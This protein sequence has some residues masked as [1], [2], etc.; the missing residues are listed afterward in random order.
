MDF[1]AVYHRAW[2]EYCY[3]KNQDELIINLKTGYDVDRV[4]IV[5]GD[6]YQAGIAGGAEKW[7]GTKEEIFFK[8]DL[9]YQRWWTTTLYPVYKRLKY[10]FILKAGEETY[11]YFENG[12]L[13][14]EQMEE[15]G[16]MLQYFICP[17]MNCS[18]ISE[19]PGWVPQTVWYQIFPERF[20]NGD[21]AINQPGI[22][23][24]E[25]R[26][27]TNEE[28]FGGDMEGIISKLDYLQDL[29]ITGIYLTPVFDSPSAHKYDTRD[30][31]KI[32]PAFGSQETFRRM[33]TEAHRRGIH[34]MLDMVFNHCGNQFPQWQDVVEKGPESR[35]YHWFMVNKW[36]FDIDSNNTKDSRYYS[37]AFH[38][39]M[40]K[41]NT[42]NQEVREYLLSVCTYWVKE[43]GVDGLRFDVGN[44]IAHTFVRYLREN[45]KKLKPDIYLLGEIWHDASEWLEG[46]QYDGVM[47]YPLTESIND[48]WVDKSLV[49]R[50]FAYM[51]NRSYTLYREQNNLALFN[52]LDSHDTDRLFT[53]VEEKET[54]FYQQLA[55]LFTMPGSPCIYY[56]TEIAM[57]GGHDPDCRRC[58]PWEEIQ[59]GVYDN[60]I[61]MIKKLIRL[62]KENK[63]F[64]SPYFHFP[65]WEGDPRVIIYEK[66][67]GH[68]EK[69]HVILNCSE[70]PEE[71]PKME[72]VFS[73]HYSD[74]ILEAGGIL[75]GS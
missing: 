62:R 42:N 58:M 25:T 70:K 5:A 41:L 3:A 8:K 21:P 15:D 49:N 28:F 14:E 71:V 66:L 54:A 61:E 72:E 75:I 1:A 20:C 52:L 9:Q 51:V 37:F 44:E 7:N 24:W 64:S 31:F 32:D 40:P 48:F 10:Y 47:N 17:W 68:G 65:D 23:Q 29:G 19:V 36:P 63:C 43:F 53:R 74:G 46:D 35:Y 39:K 59:K 33:V 11:Y 16:R 22:K 18:D 45:L 55:V 38:G 30:Y 57:S 2:G 26:A 13:T 73:F 50:D 69:I 34:V 4:W 27:V 12:F 60:R 67:T 56:G 6:P